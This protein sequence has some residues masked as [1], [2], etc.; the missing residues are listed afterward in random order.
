MRRK[1]MSGKRALLLALMAALT[2]A[3]GTPLRESSYRV[4]L[5]TLAAPP[6]EHQCTINDQPTT[7]TCFVKS[8][9]LELI[10]K[11]KAACLATGGGDEECQ[12]T[13]PASDGS[14]P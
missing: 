7:C 5:P 3:C 10:R 9:A 1:P 13:R 2:S 4:I 11:L 8:D 14:L 12:T 6:L